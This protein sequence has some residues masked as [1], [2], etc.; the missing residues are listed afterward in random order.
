MI[1]ARQHLS[2]LL[3]ADNIFL[4]LSLT[5]IAA[6]ILQTLGN[7]F[8]WDD[9]FLVK[10]FNALGDPAKLLDILTSSFWKNSSYISQA[11][12][13]LWRPLTSLLL[14]VG[15]GLFAKWTPG[16][17]LLS[18]LT[19]I[20]AATSL[21]I[22]LRT[23]LADKVDAKIPIWLGLIFLAHPM[24]AEVMCMVANIS[25]HLT[26]IFMALNTTVLIRY[27]LSTGD[28]RLR[29]L[30]TSAI[31]SF[32]AC[33]SKEVGVTTIATP[34]LAYLLVMASSNTPPN[35]KITAVAHW[36]ASII[37]VTA[38]L[39]LRSFVVN[40]GILENIHINSDFNLDVIFFG[41]GQT[42]WSLII[43]VSK[44]AHIFASN[45]QLTDWS[46]AAAAWIV[47]MSV[48]ILSIVKNKI[49]SIGAIGILVALILLI[50]SLLTVD[51]FG[52]SLRF[53][54]RYFHLPLAGLLIAALPLT[55]RNWSK[56]MRLAAPIFAILLALLS[57]IRIDE[58]EDNV[59][60]SYAEV[61]YNPGSTYELINL[62]SAYL[63]VKAFDEAEKTLNKIDTK[64]TA[65]MPP[66]YR[67]KI[68]SWH[69]RIELFKYN[70]NERALK[71]FES[72]VK[73]NP[74]D[75]DAIFDL[76]ELQAAMG[77]IKKSLGL[78]KSA[79]EAPWFQDYRRAHILKKIARY[80]IVPSQVK[81]AP[82]R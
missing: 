60:F 79:A 35:I 25:D 59:S 23:I 56:G 69:G 68:K 63:R 17:H 5:V 36:V 40:K 11:S 32:L 1:K 74:T 37:P 15:G 42:L 3:S 41:W 55:V 48:V 58:W 64:K 80:K 10:E 70:N 24:N 38:Y 6:T 50:P 78:L 67:A 28:N 30:I 73:D 27:F 75:L 33:S 21:T 12:T 52:T 61:L 4:G 81:I 20:G 49:L 31:L 51:K 19:A 43:P 53:P 46:L 2:T 18:V 22:L 65:N 47:L 57:W 72:A 66:L 34:L 14:W 44:G 8:I 76:A 26:F 39:L 13:D 54:T 71:Y 77:H 62:T 29:P 7:D 16:F 9:I 82:G 45:T